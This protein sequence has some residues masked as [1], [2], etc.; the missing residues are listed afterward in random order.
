MAV[1]YQL[2]ISAV[3]S[4][5]M[6]VCCVWIGYWM[7]RNSADKPVRSDFNPPVQSDDFEDEVSGDVFVEAMR[8]NREPE[9]RIST[10][11]K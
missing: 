8:D 10:L 11:G 3:I 2:L 6:A 7:G 1:S 5:A 4:M 9:Q